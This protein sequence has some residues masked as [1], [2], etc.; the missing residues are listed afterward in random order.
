VSASE[1]VSE[2]L[3][4]LDQVVVGSR[5]WKGLVQNQLIWLYTQLK[6][7]ISRYYTLQEDVYALD[8]AH[9]DKNGIAVRTEEKIITHSKHARQNS[10]WWWWN[11]TRPTTRR[12]KIK[13]HCNALIKNDGIFNYATD[14][15]YKTLIW[16]I[17]PNFECG[18]SR[19]QT[20]F[21]SPEYLIWHWNG[22]SIKKYF[23]R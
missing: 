2:P 14:Y 19:F 13:Y 6:V 15:Y 7:T 9:K 4:D 5:S 3:Q 16:G 8:Y 11:F 10:L 20:I 22:I 21:K 18:L 17:K 12:V 23:W 1:I